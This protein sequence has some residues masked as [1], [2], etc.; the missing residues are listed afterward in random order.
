M[1]VVFLVGVPPQLYR[2]RTHRRHVFVRG[3]QP[4]T[5]TP[6]ESAD[7]LPGTLIPTLAGSRRQPCPDAPSRL[8]APRNSIGIIP[9]K[10]ELAAI[11]EHL[12]WCSDCIDAAEE[13]ARYVDRIRG[14]IIMAN[15]DLEYLFQT[16]SGH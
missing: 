16:V 8:T 10:A 1:L 12:L 11:E 3:F 5:G 7:A 2:R 9:D 13:A 6:N 14:S 15:L 4:I